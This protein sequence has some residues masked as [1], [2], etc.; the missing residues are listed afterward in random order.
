MSCPGVHSAVD[1]SL[2]QFFILYLLLHYVRPPFRQSTNQL[3]ALPLDQSTKLLLNRSSWASTWKSLMIGKAVAGR[4]NSSGSLCPPDWIS[5]EALE[6]QMKE[7]DHLFTPSPNFLPLPSLNQNDQL[8]HLIN[9]A[10]L[11]LLSFVWRWGRTRMCT[12]C[13]SCSTNLNKHKSSLTQA[14]TEWRTLWRAPVSCM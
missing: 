1:S 9:F 4:P 7:Q 8:G 6:Y 10:H 2:L 14:D 13:N 11:F 3:I 12:N 5:R